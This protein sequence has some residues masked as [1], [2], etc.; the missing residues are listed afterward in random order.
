LPL[1]CPVLSAGI[2][3][4][5]PIG[6]PLVSPAF[7]LSSAPLPSPSPLFLFLLPAAPLCAPLR[8]GLR[9]SGVPAYISPRRAHPLPPPPSLGSGCA[10]DAAPSPT[11]QCSRING[12]TA[13]LMCPPH[14]PGIGA[15]RRALPPSRSLGRQAPPPNPPLA[16]PLFLRASGSHLGKPFRPAPSPGCSLFS[17]GSLPAVGTTPD[18]PGMCFH[19]PKPRPLLLLSWEGEPWKI[20]AR[21]Q[22]RL[23]RAA[24]HLPVAP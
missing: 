3:R 15:P 23:P 9:T 11:V 22:A 5:N 7:L 17:V 8:G 14:L 24:A 19:V 16:F 18:D 13:S 20:W 2:G 4:L 1:P 10:W 6:S 12:S 21:R